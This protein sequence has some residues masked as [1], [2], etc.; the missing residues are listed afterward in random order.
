MRKPPLRP[1]A[2]PLGLLAGLLAGCATV[3]GPAPAPA[4]TSAAAPATSFNSMLSG[5]LVPPAVPAAAPRPAASSAAPRPPATANA[6]PQAA[7]PAAAA[8]AP[9][10]AA[11]SGPPSPGAG[12]GTPPPFGVVVRD[13]RRIEGPLVLWQKDDKVWIELAPD[14]LGRPFL[15]SPKIRNGI[16][17]GFLI[18][19]LMGFPINGAGGT[20]IVEFVRVHNTV[21]L[22]AR[23]VD[24]TVKPGTPEARAVASAYSASLLGSTAVA[25]QPHPERKS[26]LVEANALFLTDL[27]GIGMQLQRAFRQGYGLD[28]GNTV[29]T[30]VRGSPAATIIETQ[31]HYYTSS[32]SGGGPGGAAGGLPGVPASQ[33]PRFVPDARSLLIGQHFSLAPLPAEPM[34]PR[35][36]DARIGHFS[37]TVLDFSDDLS[38]TPRQRYVNRWRLEK[39]DPAAEL[40]EPVKPIT[41]WIDRNVPLAYR[42]TIRDAIL[43]WNKAF[44]KIGFKDAVV[45]QQQPDDAEFDTLDAGY[46]SV[47]WMTNGEAAFSAI[48]PTHVDPR[49]GEIL[50][51]DIAIESL[52]SRSIRATRSQVLAAVRPAE[53]IDG[54]ATEFAAFAEAFGSP[55]APGG[56]QAAAACLHGSMAAEQ[57]SYALDVL[58]ARAQLEPGDPQAQQFVLDYLKDT[59]MHEVGHALGLRHNFRASRAYT[60][61]QLSD[62]EF[63]RANGTSASVMEYNAINL[64]KPGQAGGLPFQTTLGPYDYWAIEYA[65][66]SLPATLTPLEAETEL[67]RVASRSAEPHLAYGSDEDSSFAIDPETMQWDLG[68][69]PLAFAEKRLA[70]ARD[71]FHRQETRILPGDRDYAVLRRSLAYALSDVTRA[72]GVLVRHVGGV[73][74]LR[75]FPGTGRDPLQPVAPELQRRALDLIAREV[76]SLEALA[77]SPG[78]QRKLA[79]DF[80]DRLEVPGLPTDF[81]VQQRLL[82]LQRAVLGYLMS[83][84][85]AARVLDSVGKVDRGSEAFRLSE[86]YGRLSSDVWAEIATTAPL[87]TARRELQRDH[88][89][90]IAAALLRPAGTQRADVRSLLR[91]DAQKLVARIDQ[92]L[93]RGGA[94]LD[95]ESRAHLRESALMLRQALTAP[96]IRAAV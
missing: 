69:D 42:D 92:R 50:D 3:P 63:T 1:L 31:S 38:H 70:I 60:E 90:R 32:V 15:L 96:V 73:R 51:A 78:L 89:A 26:V 27:Q 35:K 82:D 87:S 54:T 81:P 52:A 25:S 2:T 6:A 18:G 91:E 21:R 43:E 9:T 17:E 83:D 53:P 67:L 34:K 7:P 4:A 36:A 11:P 77:L 84:T 74:T 79:P 64:P 16:G 45:V 40:S 61:A 80:M 48:G 19:G 72:V 46:A 57:L 86:L 10:A 66:K 75:D 33:L 47:R 58:E 24:V 93:K 22:Q 39:K 88:A 41:F 44:E 95:G 30:A 12:L 85:V 49:S 62:P 23:N 8:P 94:T 29:I 76:L 68:A 5:L 20:Q 37:T 65:Y 14:Q 56:R 28:R 71:L 55:F 59:V 13:A